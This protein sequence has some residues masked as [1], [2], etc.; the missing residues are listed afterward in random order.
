M[1]SR[2]A[3][4]M[5]GAEF[6]AAASWQRTES[7]GSP[8][9]V[10]ALLRLGALLLLSLLVLLALP[11]G[12][13]SAPLDQIEARPTPTGHM[14]Y[15]NAEPEGIVP[16]SASVAK[17]LSPA[18][19]TVR[20]ASEARPA[21]VE[22]DAAIRE[23]AAR[24]GVDANLV[25]AV[26]KVESNFNPRAVSSKGAMG[27]M[28]LMPATARRLN[29]TNPFDL[30]QNLD[31]GV[32]HLKELLANYNGNIRLTLAAYNAGIAAVARAHGIPLIAE[33]QSYIRQ[34]TELYRNPTA[35]DSGGWLQAT[36]LQVSR[37][38]KGI[39][40]ITND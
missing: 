14:V 23:A 35:M 40:T 12:A 17:E 30:R 10:P 15:V 1:K 29:V 19:K 33:T 11:V 34:I 8:V 3:G 26:V 38:S 27:L 24:H 18:A 16:A 37:D 21:P 9:V 25:R 6:V 7:A 5:D 4:V 32:R 36:A 31:A 13:H 22:I 39:L 20:A 28:Q 2:A